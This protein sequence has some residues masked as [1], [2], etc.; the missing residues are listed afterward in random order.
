MHASSTRDE[1][2]TLYRQLNQ[3]VADSLPSGP[4]ATAQDGM[5]SALVL[6]R[7]GGKVT[8]SIPP[9]PDPRCS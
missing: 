3:R 7:P 4:E 9:S 8:P 5:G 1:E 6:F 2:F